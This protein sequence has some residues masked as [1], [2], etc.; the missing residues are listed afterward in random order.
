MESG[1]EVRVLGRSAAKLQPLAL[2]GADVLTG[3]LTDA[4][5]L[6]RAFDGADAIYTLLPDDFT[7]TEHRAWQDR[8]GEAQT[9]GID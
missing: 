7:S 8:I 1:A 3:D 6:A 4:D 5:Y 9:S 2:A